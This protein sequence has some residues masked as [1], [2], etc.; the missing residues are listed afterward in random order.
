[1]GPDPF[2]HE[3]YL[4]VQ[5]GGT[6]LLLSGCAHRGIENIV[7]RCAQHLGRAPDAV[8]SGFHLTSPRSG[9]AAGAPEV[10]AVGRA[11]AAYPHT[12][13]YTCHCTGEGPFAG[14][15]GTLGDRLFPLHVGQRL[16]L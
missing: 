16:A 14:L 2:L 3:Q 5:E 8:V 13:Y 9:Q 4:L 12:R 7:S 11:L 1:M 15:Q 6:A 10:Q